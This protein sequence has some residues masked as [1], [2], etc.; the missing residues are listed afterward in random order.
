[1]QPVAPARPK[2]PNG[3]THTTAACLVVLLLSG[4][5]GASCEAYQ[6]PIAPTFCDDWCHATMRANCEGDKPDVCVRN[7]STLDV[8][9]QC[10][11]LEAELMDCYAAADRSDFRCVA[12]GGEEEKSTPADDVCQ[13]ERQAFEDCGNVEDNGQN[14]DLGACQ[15]NCLSLEV[16]ERSAFEESSGGSEGWSCGSVETDCLCA[17]FSWALEGAP[18]E[19]SF[20]D[21]LRSSLTKSCTATEVQQAGRSCEPP[22]IFEDC[23]ADF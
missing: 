11:S 15:M 12:E 17:C 5:L 19:P 21:C 18:D 16:E 23:I 4:A 10:R 22:G 2:R 13:A 7:C 9:Q 3:A 8:P 6:Y 14:V 1:M 20:F